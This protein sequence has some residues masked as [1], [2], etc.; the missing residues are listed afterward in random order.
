MHKINNEIP[1]HHDRDETF[2]D[3]IPLIVLVVFVLAGI[4][5]AIIT[6]QA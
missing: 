5:L 6:Y 3:Y 1:P 2:G 4:V